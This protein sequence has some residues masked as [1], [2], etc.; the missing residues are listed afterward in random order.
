MKTVIRKT[1]KSLVSWTIFLSFLKLYIRFLILRF[2]QLYNN[3]F[4]EKSKGNILALSNLYQ[5][6][7]WKNSQSKRLG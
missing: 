2:L 7:R 6:L 3:C 1:N 5:L 4:L